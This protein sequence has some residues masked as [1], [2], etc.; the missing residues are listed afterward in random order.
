MGF[1]SSVSEKLFELR[2]EKRAG[3]VLLVKVGNRKLGFAFLCHRRPE[4]SFKVFGY[5]FPLCSRCTGLL[6]GFLGLIWLASFQISLPLFAV[7]LL[8][9]PLAVDGLTQLAGF[10]E[11]NNV[12]RFLTGF[13]FTFGLVS[14]LVK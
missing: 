7:A 2:W 5:S 3:P 10:R 9:L 1:S 14:L 11:S 12:L 4:R 6:A 13:M 8:M